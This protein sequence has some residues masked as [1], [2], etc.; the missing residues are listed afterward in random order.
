[1]S[2]VIET[3][4]RL[5]SPVATQE[6]LEVVDVTF[7]KEGGQFFLRVFIDKPGG[8]GTDDCERLSTRLSELL[9]EQ[10]PIPQSYYLEVS[11]P[12]L[13]RP[14]KRDSD[15]ERF[16]GQHVKVHMFA[17]IAGR[18]R[19]TG[20]LL[21][22]KEGNVQLDLGKEGIVSIPRKA[23]SQARLAAELNW[24]GLK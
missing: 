6:G 20:I 22:L 14:L 1:M 3:V 10:D 16:K 17:P 23:I 11:S 15:F 18:R 4:H 9:D 12:G 13:D 5:V 7:T 2:T 21:G 19:L 24:E 8:V